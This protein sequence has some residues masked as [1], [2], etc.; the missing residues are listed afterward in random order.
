MVGA[1][2]AEKGLGFR[3]GTRTYNERDAEEEI[4]AVI[5]HAAH[6]HVPIPVACV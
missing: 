1:G 2:G 5:L 6:S 3:A 4:G